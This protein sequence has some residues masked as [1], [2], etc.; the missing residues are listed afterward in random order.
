[1][2]FIN[3][4]A[5]RLLE[6]AERAQA[7]TR[8]MTSPLD[9][10]SCNISA[11][12]PYKQQ[13]L[14]AQRALIS[15]QEVSKMKLDN[16]EQELSELKSK[17]EQDKSKIQRLEFTVKQLT[18][19]VA[20]M[21]DEVKKQAVAKRAALDE[22]DEVLNKLERALE[23]NRKKKEEMNKILQMNEYLRKNSSLA[24]SQNQLDVQ[25]KYAYL[26]NKSISEWIGL[27]KSKVYWV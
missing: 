23:D 4:H 15:S 2:S 20:D 7:S 24:K 19:E 21:T 6:R 13:L 22:R 26:S 17:Q 27:I 18:M 1:M 8:R 10:K 25:R 16:L 3:D 9:D 14:Q 12:T 5:S 11:E